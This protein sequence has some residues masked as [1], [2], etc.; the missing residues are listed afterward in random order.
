[1]EIRRIKD[2]E[3]NEAL[4]LVWEVFLRFEAPDYT[5]EGIKEFKDSIDNPNFISKMELFGAFDNNKLIGVISTREK[6]HLSL[7]F[8]RE[9]YHGKGIGKALYNY[10]CT[11]NP[12]GY[13]TVNSSLY[14]KGFYEHMGFMCDKGEQ[15][16]NG[17][18]FY[19]MKNEKIQ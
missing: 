17:L 7:L 9:N 12:D 16:I 10:V 5:D 3:R 11:L 2:F 6:H 15:C 13:F 1:M 8:V 18:K 19:P 14:A 4:R